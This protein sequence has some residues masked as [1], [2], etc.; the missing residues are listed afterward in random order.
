MGA[1]FAAL[2]LLFCV[3]RKTATLSRQVRVIQPVATRWQH[4][5]GV[6][7]RIRWHHEDV[8]GDAITAVERE[9]FNHIWK[10]PQPAVIAVPPLGLWQGNATTSDP[11]PGL[12]CLMPNETGVNHWLR[13]GSERAHP[14]SC[15]RSKRV[16]SMSFLLRFRY[17]CLFAKRQRLQQG[18][19]PFIMPS[20]CH[21]ASSLFFL[22]SVCVRIRCTCGW[23]E[24]SDTV[25]PVKNISVRV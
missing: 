12:V 24:R 20:V 21:W 3:L 22:V 19:P 7:Y 6:E 11:T 1:P 17:L 10:T 23:D 14:G 18:L 9:L 16:C 8:N 13:C 4:T 25:P 15:G 2:S 5:H